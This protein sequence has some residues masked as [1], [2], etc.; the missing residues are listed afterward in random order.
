MHR[1]DLI[2][3]RALPGL[4]R[5]GREGGALNRYSDLLLRDHARSIYDNTQIGDQE[6]NRGGRVPSS[7]GCGPHV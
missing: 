5:S 6:L 4:L 7:A 2:S 3:P 1:R